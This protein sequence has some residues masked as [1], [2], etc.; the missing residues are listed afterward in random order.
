MYWLQQPYYKISR[1]FGLIK[2]T[3]QKYNEILI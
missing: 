1:A 3:I 2:R